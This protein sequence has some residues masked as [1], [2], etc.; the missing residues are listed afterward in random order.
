MAPPKP[1]RTAV[2]LWW[3]L[4]LLL[5]LETGL[6]WTDPALET[7]LLVVNTVVGSVLAAAYLVLG[8]LVFRRTAWARLVLTVL[9]AAHLVLMIASG[10]GVGIPLLLLALGVA[11]T[12]LMWARQSSEWLTGER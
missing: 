8:S 3:V 10:A 11:G 9:A 6:A 5:L 4:A 12:V 7:R 2:V 1:L